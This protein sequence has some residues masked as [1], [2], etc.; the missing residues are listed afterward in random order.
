MPRQGRKLAHTDAII[1]QSGYERSA[2][3][4][5][6]GPI[7]AASRVDFQEQLAHGVGAECGLLLGSEQYFCAFFMLH[8][9]SVIGHGPA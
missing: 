4:V 3:T 2:A 9:A 5:T 8:Y 6:A 7:D 1:R